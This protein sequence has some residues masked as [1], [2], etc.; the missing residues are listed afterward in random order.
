MVFSNLTRLNFLRILKKSCTSRIKTR[1]KLKKNL[2][3]NHKNF[4]FSV[5]HNG[6]ATH[7]NH[8]LF[9]TTKLLI[10]CLGTVILLGI[11]L[12]VTFYTFHSYLGQQPQHELLI[13]NCVQDTLEN[14][15]MNLSTVL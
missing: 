15:S 2:S 9:N 3:P 11:L 4:T 5:I 7:S 1:H 6:G 12:V 8:G 13:T 10:L 14:I